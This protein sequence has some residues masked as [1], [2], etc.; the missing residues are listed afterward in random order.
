MTGSFRYARRS[1]IPD[2]AGAEGRADFYFTAYMWLALGEWQSSG[3]CCSSFMRHMRHF[4]P[5]FC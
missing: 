3:R 1:A 4:F 5:F 2:K